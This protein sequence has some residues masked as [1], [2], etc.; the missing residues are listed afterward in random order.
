MQLVI[1]TRFII[2]SAYIIKNSW[3]NFSFENLNHVG[4]P[5]KLAYERLKS[6]NTY[7]QSLDDCLFEVYQIFIK[8]ATVGKLN[9]FFDKPELESIT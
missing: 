1:F 2:K 3:V 7:S 4:D 5:V 6:L 8:A 9:I